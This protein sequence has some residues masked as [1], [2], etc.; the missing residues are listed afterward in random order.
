MSMKRIA[1]ALLL[2]AAISAVHGQTL[3]DLRTQS[4][5][6]DFTNANS[7]RP[8]K[9]GT[10][11]PSLCNS[12]D[13]FFKLDAPAGSN[14]YGCAALNGW[15][16]ESGGA[17]GVGSASQ[18]TDFLAFPSSNTV[19]TVGG[20]CS[21]ATPCN[22]RI[23]N[24]TYSFTHGATATLTGGTGLAYIY[25][26]SAG[27]LTVGSNLTLTCSTGC[28]AL[29]GVTSFPANAVPLF[30]WS[31]TSGTWDTSGGM[32]YRA[33]LSGRAIT[34]GIGLVGVDL[35][36]TATLSVDS[37]LVALRVPAPATATTACTAGVWATDGTYYYVCVSTN[38]WKRTALATW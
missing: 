3:V 36:G 7:T 16:V 28:Q 13:M 32:D 4:K 26:S 23:G 37:T 15:A 10:V 8:I 2:A 11:L 12:G 38:S 25:V 24:T 20:N 21:A 14:I 6:I 35:G 19:L 17:G 18:L 22:A 5:S 27:A 9:A 34:A 1:A 31:S 30:T 33:F 29:S